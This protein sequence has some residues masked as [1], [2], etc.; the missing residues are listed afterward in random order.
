MRTAKK[1]SFQFLIKIV[2]ILLLG[3]TRLYGQ[4]TSV[5]YERIVFKNKVVFTDSLSE[6]RHIIQ[7][8][9]ITNVFIKDAG[10]KSI[11]V[12]CFYF[13]FN[14]VTFDSLAD[15]KLIRFK[16]KVNF[17]NTTFKGRS[18]FAYDIFEDKVDFRMCIF[19][20]PFTD[21]KTSRSIDFNGG[22]SFLETQFKAPA[23]FSHIT[24]K[25]V[26]FFRDT[27]FDSS[28]FFKKAIFQ[29]KVYFVGA[30]F[31]TNANFGLSEFLDGAHFENTNLPDTLYF[32]NVTTI[33]KE[34]DF[35]VANFDSTRRICFINLTG[36]DIDKIR[37]NYDQFKLF[38]AETDTDNQI[39]SV[40]QRLLKK[41]QTDGYLDSYQKLDIEFQ[42][43]KYTK[44]NQWFR[45]WL[46]EWWWNYGYNKEKI[47]P[48]T[49]FLLL[50]FFFI[51]ILIGLNWGYNFLI[52]EVY[53]V[54]NIEQEVDRLE[55]KYASSKIKLF[56][57][58]LPMVFIYTCMLFF[59]LNLN[60]KH[61]RYKHKYALVY[62]LSVFMI[63]LVCAAY[64]INFVLDK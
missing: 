64:I 46:Q 55:E 28:V 11:S 49:L 37:I 45:N 7:E 16:Q 40:Y 56:F 18:S 14:E 5:V 10:L 60:T 27:K 32:N 54:E 2:F 9:S 44:S 57:S 48:N 4:D 3:W 47:F 17:L 41:F 24:C 62:L 34:L 22:T 59:I 33:T 58:W 35:T 1:Y 29:K 36:S 52:K 26:M 43:Y 12:D 6:T 13:Y 23:D 15:F 51:N 25:N 19:N 21:F 53:E 20:D 8:D 30:T 63:G 31:S 39:S 38:F 50:F 61:L 42:K